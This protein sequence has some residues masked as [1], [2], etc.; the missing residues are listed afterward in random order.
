MC[1]GDS[2][3]SPLSRH[4]LHPHQSALDDWGNP[5]NTEAQA[6]GREWKFYCAAKSL[7]LTELLCWI[8]PCT[9]VTWKVNACADRQRPNIHKLH[10]NTYFYLCCSFALKSRLDLNGKGS[11]EWLKTPKFVFHKDTLFIF[12]G[13]S[14]SRCIICAP[15]WS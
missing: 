2:P 3:P 7:A 15:R 9:S 4:P 10:M 13:P 5:K 8:L 11:R 6:E 14:K 1:N 12:Q